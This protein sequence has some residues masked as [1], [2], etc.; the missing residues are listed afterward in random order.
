MHEKKIKVKTILKK[1]IV[2]E[3]S[4][5]HYFVESVILLFYHFSVHNNVLL[6]RHRNCSALKFTYNLKHIV[7]IIINSLQEIIMNKKEQ[8]RRNIPHFNNDFMLNLCKFNFFL[9]VLAYIS[10]VLV[11]LFCCL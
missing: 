9:I 3:N 4:H 8:K 11:F 5:K 6:C 7:A 1:L 10:W 2:R